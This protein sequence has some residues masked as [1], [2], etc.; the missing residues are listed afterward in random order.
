MVEP[1]FQDEGIGVMVRYTVAGE[2]GAGFI[3]PGS[4]V[5][6]VWSGVDAFTYE[7]IAAYDIHTSSIF[8]PLAVVIARVG[9]TLYFGSYP[10]RGIHRVAYKSKFM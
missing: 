1:A 10:H 4:L 2:V 5:F 9:N 3:A 7:A 8:C 6:A